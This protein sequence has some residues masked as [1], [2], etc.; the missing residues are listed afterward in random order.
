MTAPKLETCSH[1]DG[2]GPIQV[3]LC[4]GCDYARESEESNRLL[5]RRV[6]GT[7]R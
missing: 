3:G 5:G 4:E 6:G 1:C 7:P 2:P